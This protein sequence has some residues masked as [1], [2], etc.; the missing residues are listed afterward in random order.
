M[1]AAPGFTAIALLV[2]ALGI[3][4]T[5][6]IFSVVDAVLLWSLPY[7]H[8]EQLVYLWSPNP[9]FKGVPQELG[10]NV[11]D[12]YDWQ[13]LSRSFSEMTLLRQPTL[14]LVGDGSVERVPAALVT[15]RFFET[16]QARAAMGRTPDGN[17]DRTGHE[18][19]AVISDALWRSRFGAAA[20]IIGRRVQLNRKS[21]TVVGAMSKDFGY[22]F[23]GDVPYD[24]RGF[25]QTD[26]LAAGGVYRQTANRPGELR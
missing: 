20:D 5:T 13:R 2:I 22:P 23:D 3:G 21:Y 9:N 15:G 24:S 10:P 17:D 6:A 11:P 16:L 14:N 12:F 26:I 8:P 19:V 1:A 25:K 4:A 7:G 18:Q